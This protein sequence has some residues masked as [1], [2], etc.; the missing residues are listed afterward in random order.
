[1]TV[2]DSRS[3][4]DSEYLPRALVEHA[5]RLLLGTGLDIEH[6][7]QVAR[8]DV[9]GPPHLVTLG[10]ALRAGWSLSGGPKSA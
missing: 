5:E 7:L 2:T 4:G 6:A 8:G 3:G 1:V 10:E 9:E